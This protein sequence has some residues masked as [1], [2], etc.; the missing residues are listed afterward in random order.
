MSFKKELEKLQEYA[1]EFVNIGDAESY[2][3]SGQA[4]FVAEKAANVYNYY[5][6]IISNVEYDSE[7]WNKAYDIVN[8]IAEDN[9]SLEDWVS[10]TLEIAEKS[11]KESIKKTEKAKTPIKD[12]VDDLIAELEGMRSWNMNRINEIEWELSDLQKRLALEKD[13]YSEEEFNNIMNNINNY[14]TKIAKLY[15][16]LNANDMSNV[17]K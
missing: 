17:K 5:Y 12:I 8:K 3:A 15:K 10:A 11:K 4:K 16:S 9:P 6:F 2:I 13:N 7:E 14:L 1:D